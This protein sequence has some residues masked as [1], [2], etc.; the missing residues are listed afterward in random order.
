MNKQFKVV[1]KVSCYQKFLSHMF[2]AFSPIS[3][4]ITA[5]LLDEKLNNGLP[6]FQIPPEA[7]KRLDSGLMIV[8]YT[9]AV[10]ASENKILAHPAC[11]DSIPTSAIFE[12]FVSMGVTAAQKATQ[13]LKNVG[14][15]VAIELLCAVQAIEFRGSE[16]LGKGTK[17]AYSTIRKTVPMLKE[18]K[19]LS[20]DIEKIRQIVKTCIILN[21]IEKTLKID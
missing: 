9:A 3:E 7:K 20:E 14:Y 21:E 2:S 6:A 13:I 15:I 12:N 10:L 5:S 18:D 1:F 17:I 16:K 4:R 19:V 11:V 8:Q